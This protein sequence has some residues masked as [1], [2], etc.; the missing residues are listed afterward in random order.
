M[1]RFLFFSL[2]FKKFPT[3]AAKPPV[4]KSEE[5]IFLDSVSYESCIFLCLSL[6]SPTW[7]DVLSSYY[8]GHRVHARKPENCPQQL[9]NRKVQ[10]FLDES[11]QCICKAVIF[12]TILL[13]LYITS[14]KEIRYSE[15]IEDSYKVK[16]AFRILLNAYIF[17]SNDIYL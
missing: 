6:V 1:C 11:N 3:H 16:L 10:W 4:S 5:Y 7:H 13:N 14:F 12:F 17:I 8:C 15:C 2:N 9:T